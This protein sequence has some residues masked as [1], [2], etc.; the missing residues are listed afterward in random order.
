MLRS[1][2]TRYVVQK[3]RTYATSVAK[4]PFSDVVTVQDSQPTPSQDALI[5]GKGLMFHLAKVLVPEEKR[6]MM[7]V[8]FS[9]RHPQRILPGS[10]LTVGLGQPPYTFSGVLISTRRRGVDTSFVLRNVIQRTGVEM[11]FFVNSPDLKSIEVV[12]SPRDRNAREGRKIRRAK[13]FYL[14]HSPEK[15]TALSSGVKR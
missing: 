7:D 4:Y 14:R 6:H 3:Q 1:R 8:L 15:M 5:K 9:R 12:K 10:V 13:L 2:F 11:Q